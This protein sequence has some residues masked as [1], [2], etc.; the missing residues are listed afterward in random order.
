MA[1]QMVDW[2]VM[3]IKEPYILTGREQITGYGRSYVR[4]VRKQGL[5]KGGLADILVTYFGST[6]NIKNSQD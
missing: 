1:D 2:N 5:G 4:V 3:F 6:V